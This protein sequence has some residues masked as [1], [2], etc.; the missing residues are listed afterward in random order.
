[1]NPSPIR[2]TVVTGPL[3]NQSPPPPTPQ[4]PVT[5]AGSP[6]CPTVVSSDEMIVSPQGRPV[7]VGEKDAEPLGILPVTNAASPAHPTV[8]SSDEMIVSPQNRPVLVGEKDAEPLGA[9]LV[10]NAA[11]P[12]RPVVLSSDKMT[13]SPQGRAALVGRKDAGP[14]GV[15][16]TPLSDFVSPYL[17]LPDLHFDVEWDDMMASLEAASSLMDYPIMDLA[18]QTVQNGRKTFWL[19]MHSVSDALKAR[20]FLHHRCSSDGIL[21]QCSFETKEAFEDACRRASRIWSK[22]DPEN[23]GRRRSASPPRHSDD[24][25]SSRNRGRS[26]YRHPRH[27][28]SSP[29]YESS[30]SPVSRSHLHAPQQRQLR[31]PSLSCLPSPCRG[32]SRSRSRSYRNYYRS[33]ERYRTDRYRSSSRGRR[34]SPIVGP[35]SQPQGIKGTIPPCPPSNRL[36]RGESLVDH[37]ADR[38][39]LASRMSMP[40]QE[41]LPLHPYRGRRAGKKHRKPGDRPGLGSRPKMS[42]WGNS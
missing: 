1:M 37:L 9:L 5:N 6:T 29:W 4:S 22:R 36:K 14:L 24:H 17:K 41:D 32:R 28:Q 12:A 25:Y 15:L 8:V 19:C 13:V 33:D 21:L 26:P 18:A 38:H 23:K 35:S 39:S 10:T 11:S 20:G 27:R 31:S 40:L 16:E 2:Q 30:P 42:E 3:D 7:L 34:G